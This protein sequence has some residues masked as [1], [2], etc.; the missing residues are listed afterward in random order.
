MLPQRSFKTFLVKKKGGGVCCVHTTPPWRGCADVVSRDTVND[1]VHDTVHDNALDTLGNTGNASNPRR[2][3]L[4]SP[5]SL[6]LDP[7]NV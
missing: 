5:S 4:W 3:E 6:S 2:L 1:A 7:E